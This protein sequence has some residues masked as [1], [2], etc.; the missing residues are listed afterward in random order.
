MLRTPYL[1]KRRVNSNSAEQSVQPARVPRV[2]GHVVRADSNMHIHPEHVMN[3][4]V[5]MVSRHRGLENMFQP[6][7]DVRVLNI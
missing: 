2:C 1:L 5:R 3:E 7:L 4:F 6:R